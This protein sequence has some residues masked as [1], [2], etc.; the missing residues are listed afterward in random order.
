MK[1]K[2]F[3]MLAVVVAVL[4]AALAPVALAAA[5]KVTLKGPSSGNVTLNKW[6]TVNGT[7]KGGGGQ[8][9]TFVTIQKKVDNAWTKVAQVKTKWLNGQGIF[10]ARLKATNPTMSLLRYRAVYASGGVNGYSKTLILA[11]Q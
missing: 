2:T 7:V 11:V 8:N 6:F 5:P 4:V 3:V 10:H 9:A 1:L